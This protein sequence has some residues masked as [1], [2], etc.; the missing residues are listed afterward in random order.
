LVWEPRF[1]GGA[2][3][4][5]WLKPLR[6]P[7]DEVTRKIKHL[8]TLGATQAV[9]VLVLNSNHVYNRTKSRGWDLL[10]ERVY[11]SH[12]PKKWTLRAFNSG[13]QA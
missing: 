8:G 10:I 4:A 9:K 2:R 1:N 3:S 5:G 6:Y 13:Y 11:V 7:R 12:A